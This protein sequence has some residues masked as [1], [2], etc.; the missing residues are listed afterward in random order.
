MRLE[1]LTLT[2]FAACNGIRLVAYLPQIYKA[3]HDP[4]GASAISCTT[5][6]LFLIAHLSTIAYALVNQ[7]DTWLAICFGGNALS[8]VAILGVAYW[9][10]WQMRDAGRA[11]RP[12]SRRTEPWWRKHRGRRAATA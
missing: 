7:A 9:K 4:N 12:A 8:C 10:R 1:E 2:M 6:F 5:W 3:A 11:G